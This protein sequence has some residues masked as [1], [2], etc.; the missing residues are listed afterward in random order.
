MCL[1]E[2]LRNSDER[3]PKS[4]SEVIRQLYIEKY[5]AF[6]FFFYT[7]LLPGAGDLFVCAILSCSQIH[8]T[9]CMSALQALTWVP[10][11]IQVLPL[12]EVSSW[13]ILFLSA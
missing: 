11:I 13:L 9:V 5:A 3:K 8:S 2:L 4:K 1:M 6:S 10:T 12:L 7:G